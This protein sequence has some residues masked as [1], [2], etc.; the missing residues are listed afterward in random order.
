MHRR[1]SRISAVVVLTGAVLAVTAPDA[2][3]EPSAEVSPANP[4]PGQQVTLTL[5]GCS[6]PTDGGRAEGALVGDGST[7]R[8]PVEATDLRPS[9]GGAVTGTATIS[10]DAEPGRRA[11]IYFACGSDRNTVANAV[12]TFAGAASASPSPS[13]P[14][15][16]AAPESAPGSAPASPA[17]AAPSAPARGGLG[18]AAG[19]GGTTEVATGAAIC[20]AAAAGGAAL[21]RRRRRTT[22]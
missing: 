2:A 12:I 17:P 1:R 7:A 3:A 8:F 15:S 20:L 19:D 9:E 13:T 21:L 18:G 11:T 10:P 22:S 5:R 16:P 4:R 14:A 6:D